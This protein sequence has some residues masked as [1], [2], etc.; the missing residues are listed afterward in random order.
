[1]GG[2]LFC[3]RAWRPRPEKFV[4]LEQSPFRQMD[5]EI[6]LGIEQHLEKDRFVL[7]LGVMILVGGLG[8]PEDLLLWAFGRKF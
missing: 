7:S 4:S 5:L 8:R 2:D 1:M 6:S 3:E